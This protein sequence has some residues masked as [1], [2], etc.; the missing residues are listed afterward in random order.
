[1]RTLA[2][3]ARPHLRLVKGL[4]RWTSALFMFASINL[5]L[6]ADKLIETSVFSF[7]ALKSER[8][9]W[10]DQFKTGGTSR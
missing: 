1:M 10:L 2:Q 7:R 6:D 3:A 8:S 9:E 5:L 4:R